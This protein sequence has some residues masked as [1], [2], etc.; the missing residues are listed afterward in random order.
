MREH[1]RGGRRRRLAD[2]AGIGF[3]VLLVAGFGLSRV[4]GD[5]GAPAATCADPVAWQEAGDLV[6]QPAAV[7]GPVADA[8]YAPEV[9]G[10]PTF[11]N[12]GNPHP[13]ANRFDV[14]V[15]DD[16]RDE[17]AE[18]PEQAFAGARVCVTGTVRERDG[19]PQVVL[20]SSLSIAE[21]D[22]S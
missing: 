9:G 22:D 12:L 17:F 6:G 21:V 20:D 5:A 18:P 11:L 13:D 10:A 16:V 7:T 4:W 2:A 15:Y 19:V 1:N 8:T 14:V 3:A